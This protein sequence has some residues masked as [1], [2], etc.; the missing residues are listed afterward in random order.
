MYEKG[1]WIVAIGG[2]FDREGNIKEVSF[3]IASILEIGIDDLL[4]QPKGHYE[5]PK[6]VPKKTCQRI[7]IDKIKVYDTIRKPQCGDLVYY[8]R[9]DWN[10]RLVTSVSHVLELRKDAGVGVCAL[11]L[12][13]D[14]QVWVPIENLLVLDVHNSND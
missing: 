2:T 13:G 5:R 9:K 3:T 11:I 1:E 6:F 7:P 4:I 10:K 12:I 8:Y 14:K